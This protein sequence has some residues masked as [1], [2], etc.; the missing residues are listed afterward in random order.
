MSFNNKFAL[1][2]SQRKSKF[3]AASAQDVLALE[4]CKKGVD[5]EGFFKSYI[6]NFI[7]MS[8]LCFS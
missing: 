4:Y 3:S 1:L 6:D 7:G 2:L 5:Q 8:G